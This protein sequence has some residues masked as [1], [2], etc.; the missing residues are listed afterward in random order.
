MRPPCLHPETAPGMQ[1]TCGP[2]LLGQGVSPP[3]SSHVFGLLSIS[4]LCFCLCP[5]LSRRYVYSVKLVRLCDRRQVSRHR[6][7]SVRVPPPKTFLTGDIQLASPRSQCR[8]AAGACTA[9]GQ[10]A[11][12]ER[13]KKIQTLFPSADSTESAY[14]W[15]DASNDPRR[16]TTLLAK[17]SLQSEAICLT[18]DKHLSYWDQDSHYRARPSDVRTLPSSGPRDSLACQPSLNKGSALAG[19]ESPEGSGDLNAPAALAEPGGPSEED[20]GRTRERGQEAT[21]E[22][23]AGSTQL[24][25]KRVPVNSSQET[26]NNDEGE[27]SEEERRQESSVDPRGEA[28][29]ETGATLE[30]ARESLGEASEAR[31]E[32]ALRL[33]ASSEELNLTLAEGVQSPF[34]FSGQRALSPRL[35][36]EVASLGGESRN[37]EDL[38]VSAFSDDEGEQTPANSGADKKSVEKGEGSAASSARAA[39]FRAEDSQSL[40][41]SLRHPAVDAARESSESKEANACC[42]AVLDHLDRDIDEVCRLLESRPASSCGA[43]ESEGELEKETGTEEETRN[44]SEDRASEPSVEAPLLVGSARGRRREREDRDLERRAEFVRRRHASLAALGRRVKEHAAKRRHRSLSSH[45]RGTVSELALDSSPASPA[46][47]ASLATRVIAQVRAE[48]R[49]KAREALEALEDGAEGEHGLSRSAGPRRSRT[50]ELSRLGTNH[51]A[52]EAA[53][54]RILE[55]CITVKETDWTFLASGETGESE[56]LASDGRASSEDS[57]CSGNAS[58]A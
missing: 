23:V 58:G 27:A 11:H 54:R 12:E 56:K 15:A 24:Q 19:F 18:F 49:A 35:E 8:A 46:R 17:P 40:S 45:R 31:L 50:L 52:Y 13:A 28:G 55:G 36:V 20:G 29:K 30:E 47:R 16:G 42:P 57:G 38:T 48:E 44:E 3:L 53:Y 5:V 7:A 4:T 32:A 37:D 33:C 10:G 2:S 25:R 41:G 6:L 34:S 14:V 26:A 1:T 21:E 39:A 22:S 43:R 9:E 51:D